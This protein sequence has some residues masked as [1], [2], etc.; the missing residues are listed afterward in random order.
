MGSA[1]GRL[2]LPMFFAHNA[3]ASGPQARLFA[4][5]VMAKVKVGKI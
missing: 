3:L 1:Q 2:S 4:E 5:K